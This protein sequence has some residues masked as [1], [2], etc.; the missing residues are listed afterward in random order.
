M[1]DIHID[2]VCDY[3]LEH[4]ILSVRDIASPDFRVEELSRRNADYRVVWSGGGV[5]V[6]QTRQEDD[7]GASTVLREAR[8]LRHLQECGEARALQRTGPEF[9]FLDEP[10]RLAVARLVHPATSLTKL[11]VNLGNVQFP[12]EVGST[13]GHLLADFHDGAQEIVDDVAD[14]VLDEPPNVFSL[15]TNL[16]NNAAQGPSLAS[17]MLDAVRGRP[18]MELAAARGAWER[19]RGLVHSDLRWD[20]ILVTHGRSPWGAYNLRIID[21]ETARVGN[22]AWDVATYLAETF[23]FWAFTGSLR[24]G[25]DLEKIHDEPVFPREAVHA[26]NRA[27]LDAYRSRRPLDGDDVRALLPPAL[28]LVAWEFAANLAKAR[29]L[30]R[31]PATTRAVLDVA[32]EASKAPDAVLR[33]LGVH[34]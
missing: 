33:R 22:P 23:R 7:A 12:P 13:V 27:F 4:G 32:D 30:N 14:L 11:F 1:N 10:N 9:V 34:A 17:L 19:T 6:K 21:W 25:D 3:L 29:S 2:H 15:P 16:E 8:L 18:C 24:H 20:N 26:H 28:L 31:I 5:L